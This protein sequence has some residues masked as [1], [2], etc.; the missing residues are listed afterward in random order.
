M[1]MVISLCHPWALRKPAHCG[2]QIM[3]RCLSRSQPQIL[4]SPADNFCRCGSTLYKLVDVPRSAPR[5]RPAGPSQGGRAAAG[6]TRCTHA[7]A[8]RAGQGPQI[9]LT[10]WRLPH[11]PILVLASWAHARSTEVCSCIPVRLR[12]LRRCVRMH[13]NHAAE[14]VQKIRKRAFFHSK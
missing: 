4:T 1:T 6:F 10:P 11:S 13:K 12:C 7:Y 9:D 8:I 2:F 14:R 3:P 5:R